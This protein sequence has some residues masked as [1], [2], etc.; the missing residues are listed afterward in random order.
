MDNQHIFSDFTLLHGDCMDL[1]RQIEDKSVDAIFADPPYD[2]PQLP[3]IPKMV[4]D[5]QLLA[6]GGIFIMEHSEKNSFADLPLFIMH[7][8]YGAVNFS[9][10]ENGAVEA[11]EN[12]GAE[13]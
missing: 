2:L 6:D 9:F 11:D 3:E 1:L 12:D 7:K 8:H 13:Q 10:F 4:I 5:N